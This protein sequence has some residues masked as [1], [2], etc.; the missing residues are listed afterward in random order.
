MASGH[1]N[2]IRATRTLV[3]AGPVRGVCGVLATVRLVV[4]I[5]RLLIVSHVAHYEHQ[6]RLFAYGPYAREIDIWA[7]LFPEIIIAAP[8]HRQTPPGDAIAFQHSNI[9]L[10]PQWETGGDTLLAKVTQLLA[11]PGHLWRLARAMR[12][13]DAIHVR[14]PGNLGLLGCLLA[15][16]FRKPRVAKYAGQWN[17]YSGEPRAW[18]LQKRLLASKWWNA[19]V[20][21][22][23]KWPD[24]PAHIIPFFTSVMGREQMARAVAVAR[25]RDF[26]SFK[27]VLFVGRLS[28]QRNVDILV[29]AVDICRRR[30]VDL[31]CRIVG[32]GEMRPRLAE[33][34]ARLNLSASVSFSGAL[35]YEQVMA[36]YAGADVLVLVAESEGWGKATLEGMA[37]GLVCVGANRG[38]VPWI[39]GE[40]RGVIV[41][42]RDPE[43][44]AHVLTQIASE[45]ERAKEMAHRGALWAQGYSLE[46]LKEAIRRVL[47]SWWKV[48][49]NGILRA[50][51][52]CPDVAL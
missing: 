2:L 21:I 31:T 24:Q 47:E 28:A 42:P 9:S 13:A 32:D 6:G 1:S 36:E 14:C 38:P 5:R 43:A 41:E 22:Y 10:A 8:V 23:G 48:K 26:A 44:L 39:L 12:G 29:E 50:E 30:G 37:F 45:P 49:L 11:L 17:D 25:Q 19:P 20:L 27:R 15:P 33:Q 40:G 3:L 46:A 52:R 18:R 35:P 16:C 7:E 51:I 34:V 4:K